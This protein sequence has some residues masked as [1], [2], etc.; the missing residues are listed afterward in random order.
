M[1]RQEGV[2][3]CQ[4]G[5]KK[6][7]TRYLHKTSLGQA[8]TADPSMVNWL[9]QSAGL[10]LVSKTVIQSASHSRSLLSEVSYGV[11]SSYVR[12]GGYKG[13][14]TSLHVQRCRC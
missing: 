7:P 6:P 1:R 11:Q 8:V 10:F 9:T 3:G 2:K 13:G 4:A 5:A 14:Q 12:A